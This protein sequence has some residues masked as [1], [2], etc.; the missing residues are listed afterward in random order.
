M[1]KSILS[2]IISAV[3][4]SLAMVSTPAFADSSSWVNG[5]VNA[6]NYVSSGDGGFSAAFTGGAG[7]NS[8]SGNTDT[9]VS[10]S[11]A[12]MNYGS[13]MATGYTNAGSSANE[14]YYYGASVNVGSSTG[15]TAYSSSGMSMSNADANA[16][17]TAN[18]NCYY[19]WW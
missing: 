16:S 6:G 9:M 17:G 12:G 5:G 13:G 8:W 10:G 7:A 18:N 3:V 11:T 14:D 15:T 4:L 19:C 2:S 1:K